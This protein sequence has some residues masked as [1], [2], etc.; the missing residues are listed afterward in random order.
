M[1]IALP[2]ANHSAQT[3]LRCVSDSDV[4][5]F[6]FGCHGSLSFLIVNYSSVNVPRPFLWV[7]T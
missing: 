5:S 7:R 1:S 3:Y 6:D 4:I 2:K